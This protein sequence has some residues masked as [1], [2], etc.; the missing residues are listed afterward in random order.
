MTSRASGEPYRIIIIKSTSFSQADVFL[1]DSNRDI[2]IFPN[3]PRIKKYFTEYYIRKC[4][5]FI[6]LDIFISKIKIYLYITIRM[7]IYYMR[8]DKN[9][10]IKLDILRDFFRSGWV[11]QSLDQMRDLLGYAN[12][13]WVKLFLQKLVSEGILEMQNT[14]YT[15]SN[16]LI[17][18]PF[19]ESVRAGLPFTPET[20]PTSQI[21]L[22]D[23]LIDHPASTY[24]VKVKGDSMEDAG[25]REW[26]IVIL[27]RSLTPKNGDI[28]IAS[29][30]GEVTLKYFERKW[31]KIRLIPANP[32]YEPI[33]VSWPCEILWVVSGSVRKYH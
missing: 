15:G 14:V 16:K 9:F 1:I 10:N 11:F 31:D 3:I 6:C 22:D 5:D 25:I 12:R 2:P 18:Y 20:H 30:D 21:D 24:F 27:D 7:Y 29:L 13:S 23:Y 17:G 8:T 32:K 33:I 26:D 19:F 28:V 4:L